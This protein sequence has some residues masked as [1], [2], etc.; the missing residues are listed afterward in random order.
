MRILEF[1]PPS[2]IRKARLLNKEFKDMVDTY[3]SIYL[4]QRIE[5]FGEDMPRPL[6]NMTERQYNDLLS[7]KGCM[8][9]TCSDTKAS[10]THWSWEKRLCQNC[11]KLKI[12]REDRLQKIWQNQLTRNIINRL[13]ECIP[14]GMH[15]SFMKPH[16]FIEDVD[17][18]PRGAPRL[19]R[20]HFKSDVEKI[21][22]EYEALKPPPYKENPEH[23]AAEKASALAAHQA[24]E[25][26]FAEKRTEFLEQ[27]KAKNDEH[28]KRVVK[29]ETCIRNRR[30]V[31]KK[32]Y[33]A[34]RNAR[35]ERFTKGAETDLPH[36]PIE[37][38]QNTKAYKAAVRIFRDPGTERGWQLLK[39]KIE[40]EWDES[41]EKKTHED[42][43]R[44]G[45]TDDNSTTRET[46]TVN[47][48]EP[49]P[50][51]LP[52]PEQVHHHSHHHHIHAAPNSNS[53]HAGG[54]HVLNMAASQQSDLLQSMMMM[55]GHNQ[56][57]SASYHTGMHQ[58]PH[59]FHHSQRVHHSVM[60]PTATYHNEALN[61]ND[62][63]MSGP[64]MQIPPSYV[65][66]NAFPSGGSFTTNLQVNPSSQQAS[67]T[68]IPINSLL[69]G[70]ASAF[71][72]N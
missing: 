43:A 28:M 36:I 69:N 71:N 61:R 7:G 53:F 12:E 42:K 13:L 56:F 6:G 8:E 24:L 35:K 54:Q 57:H 34:N 62:F 47:E 33:D 2:F 17:S 51:P 19:Y 27:R 16:D 50:E 63:G 68:Q 64:V 14:V 44:N 26:E 32:P 45:N 52:A 37:F 18:R 3:Q 25:A 11:W 70:P 60:L 5:N 10:R 30:E 46:S 48:A 49:T 29:I 22:E 41:T 40:A 39:P 20:Y 9:D 4:N 67:N 65:G 23:S 55:G 21:V 72:W 58:T 15:D 59:G 1:T 66:Y 38:V 31:E